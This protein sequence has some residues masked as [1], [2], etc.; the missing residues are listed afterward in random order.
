MV[1]KDKILISDCKLD[2]SRSGLSIR[3]LTDWISKTI[4]FFPF[5]PHS[6]VDLR[7]LT[8][9]WTQATKTLNIQQ[10]RL[11]QESS[12]FPVTKSAE[13]KPRRMT[14]Q[15]EHLYQQWSSRQRICS[16]YR[17]RRGWQR[18]RWLHG[19]TDSMDVSLGRLWALVIDSK[20][21]HASVHGVPKSWTRLSD[22]T[23]LNWTD[24]QWGND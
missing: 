2:G 23:E 5:W 22:W 4:F 11:L 17:R 13:T 9:D 20:A 19:I 21:W 7:S 15:A 8:R 14:G 6:L 12:E 3:N 24:G 18:M 16:P 1:S 10:N